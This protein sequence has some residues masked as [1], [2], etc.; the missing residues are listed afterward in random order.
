MRPTR[1]L[2]PFA[3]LLAA[4]AAVSPLLAQLGSPA[5]SSVSSSPSTNT[6][7]GTPGGI[8]TSS[9]RLP[10][11]PLRQILP[12]PA[13]LDGSKL[14]PDKYPEYGMIGDVEMPGDDVTD[15]AQN[16]QIGRAHV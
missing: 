6:G 2:Y 16:Q 13:L 1:V 14:A 11:R 12:D 10:S 3:A 15:P 8:S 4:A 5:N 7:S 9:S